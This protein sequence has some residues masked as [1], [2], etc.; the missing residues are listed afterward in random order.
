MYV[1]H[2]PR[3][4]ERAHNISRKSTQSL[5]PCIMNKA[6]FLCFCVVQI[7]FKLSPGHVSALPRWLGSSPYHLLGM[8]PWLENDSKYA[9][10]SSRVSKL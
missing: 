7:S 9:M 10:F 1:K 2:V 6:I 8:T 4:H 5:D 3:L